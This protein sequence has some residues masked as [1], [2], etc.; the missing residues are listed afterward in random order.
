MTVT[1]I[2]LE[3]AQIVRPW[4]NDCRNAMRTGWTTEQQQANFIS[5]NMHGDHMYWWFETDYM[6]KRPHFDNWK[7][8]AAGGLVNINMFNRNAEIALMVGPDSRGV[9]FGTECVDWILHEGFANQNLKTIYGEVY[10]CGAVAFWLGICEQYKA[11]TTELPNRKYWNGRYFDSMY[12]SI[13]REKY[14]ES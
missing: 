1:P 8:T 11:Y 2:T 12:F 5:T 7:S 14:N 3:Q 10:H 9:G 4:R 6:G 13:D